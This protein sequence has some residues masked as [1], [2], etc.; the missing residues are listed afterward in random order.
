M[1]FLL[2]TGCD[3]PSLD[4]EPTI[5]VNEPSFEKIQL[6]DISVF[7]D[8]TNTLLL[9]VDIFYDNRDR[10]DRVDFNGRTNQ[11]FTFTYSQNNR[12]DF[13]SRE[14]LSSTL[15]YELTYTN[16]LI[17]IR[18]QSDPNNVTELFIDAENRIARSNSV[19]NGLNIE[20]QRLIYG[21]ND[22]VTRVNFIQNNQLR[23]FIDR[24]HNF[25]TNPFRDT[26]D[27]L[28]KIVF[29]EFLPNSFYTADS[30]TVTERNGTID[31]ITQEI[32]YTYTSTNELVAER[33]AIIMEGGSTRSERTVFNYRSE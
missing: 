15:D 28:R 2:L 7:D 22:N 17:E 27:V 16:Q 31:T 32:T 6:S 14:T 19:L 5:I 13:Y 21:A 11:T 20:D 24:E 3:D 26:N 9:Q 18:Q 29:Q 33:L 30:Q 1:C 4:R 12:L 10:I 23:R 8:D 25:L